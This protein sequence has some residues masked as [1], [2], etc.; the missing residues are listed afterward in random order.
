MKTVTIV[1][2]GFS[3]LSL[4]YLLAKRGISVKVLEKENRV[5]GLL[6]THRGPLGISETGANG[7]MAGA[8]FRQFCDELGLAV[9]PARSAARK[10]YIWREEPRRWPLS[11]GETLATGGRALRG[12]RRL[13]PAQ[14]ESISDWGKSRFGEPFTQVVLGPALQGIYAG[15]P[16]RM[17][18]S[19]ILGST[20][21][22]K[23]RE[24][25]ELV[26][27][28]G[29]MGELV[30]ALSRAVRNAGVEICLGE[31]AK[32]LAGP[33]VLATSAWDAAPFLQSLGT[34]EALPLV[35][36][37]IFFDRPQ[38]RLP[39]FGCLFPRSAPTPA[40]GVL[41]NSHI[42]PGRDSTYNET[43]ILGGVKEGI[44]GSDPELL[45]CVRGW[46]Q[47]LLGLEG[48][49]LDAKITRWPRALPH[50]TL[51]WETT[52][53]TLTPPQGIYLHGNWCGGIGL[54]KILDR[55][56]ALAEL[57]NKDLS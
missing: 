14:G 54:G 29:G 52:L 30:D 51:A 10:R 3:G 47:D 56:H 43:W 22:G 1:G 7:V 9:L 45:E 13:A 35:T 32:S 26:S 17:S 15:D 21:S 36:A 31:E 44:P 53:R 20:F 4:A 41:M 46:R 28:S 5:G 42:F 24:K 50:Y 12:I 23:K 6:G 27:F 39:G 48:V 34:V 16:E 8:R 49:I 55:S 25:S 38:N 57:I 37:T 40:L 33:V 2:A 18:A 11:L 19:L